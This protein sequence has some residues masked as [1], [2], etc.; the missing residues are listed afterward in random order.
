MLLHRTGDP[1]RLNAYKL[2]RMMGTA[3]WHFP[4]RDDFEPLA[5]PEPSTLALGSIGVAVAIGHFLRRVTSTDLLNRR[6]TMPR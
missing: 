2:Q 3:I 4:R 1:P 6:A 5:T